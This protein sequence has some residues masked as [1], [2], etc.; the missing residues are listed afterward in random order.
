MSTPEMLAA[1]IGGAIIGTVVI[2]LWVLT[3]KK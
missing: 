3:Y 1:L 2:G